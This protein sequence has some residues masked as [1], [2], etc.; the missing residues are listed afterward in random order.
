[1]Q[2]KFVMFIEEYIYVELFN[3]LVFKIM[4][5]VIGWRLVEKMY[6]LE[7]YGKYVKFKGGFVK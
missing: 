5:Q 4:V 2:V 6:Q 3:K 7:K 1:M